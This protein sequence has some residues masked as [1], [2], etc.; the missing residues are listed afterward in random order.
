VIHKSFN[1]KHSLKIRRLPTYYLGKM[2]TM[3]HISKVKNIKIPQFFS[4]KFQF[5]S[6]K[7]NVL[8]H[9]IFFY[10][11]K[12]EGETFSFYFICLT[13]NIYL[14]NFIITVK[15]KGEGRSVSIVML[16]SLQV[17]ISVHMYAIAVEHFSKRLKIL[18]LVL[19]IVLGKQ[20]TSKT[21]V[22]TK[23]SLVV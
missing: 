3:L 6:N 14:N 12:I 23:H 19:V 21:A 17:I 2:L 7:K 15:C 4:L 10:F 22:K 9:V 5:F 18:P 16:L 1:Y 11:Y 8:S 20:Q 13:L